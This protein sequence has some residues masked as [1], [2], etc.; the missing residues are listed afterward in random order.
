MRRFSEWRSFS[1]EKLSI[2]S[3]AI[4]V[5]TL[6]RAE[7]PLPLD[8]T[9]AIDSGGFGALRFLLGSRIRNSLVGEAPVWRPTLSVGPVSQRVWMTRPV[10]DYPSMLRIE[11]DL[12]WLS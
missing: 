10:P 2:C 6:A 8:L 11:L 9:A 7:D 1:F 5:G 3:E 4:A 12:S